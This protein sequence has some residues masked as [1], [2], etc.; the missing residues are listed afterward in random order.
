MDFT[1]VE[2]FFSKELGS[3]Y[4]KGLSYTARPQD[5]KLLALLPKWLEEG[6]IVPG[7]PPVAQVTG[8]G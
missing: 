2:D 4:C 7:R 6:K 3:Q 8:E 5:T 1:A